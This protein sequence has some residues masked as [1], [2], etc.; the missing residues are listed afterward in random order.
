LIAVRAVNH[1]LLDA[2]D[3]LDHD[4]NIRLYLRD[5]RDDFWIEDLKEGCPLVSATFF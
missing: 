1:A 3:L 4:R 5:F 2:H